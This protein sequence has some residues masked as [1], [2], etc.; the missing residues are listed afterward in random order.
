M[1]PSSYIDE[2]SANANIKNNNLIEFYI[3]N[4]FQGNGKVKCR[5]DSVIEIVEICLWFDFFIFLSGSFQFRLYFQLMNK[6][7]RFACPATK[8]D[9]FSEKFQ[10]AFNPPPHFWK[11]MLQIFYDRYGCIYAR[12]HDGQ[13]V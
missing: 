10:T 13:I 5:L 9:E 4:F 3:R 6:S 2:L 12:R 7:S 11:I 1:N 8:S